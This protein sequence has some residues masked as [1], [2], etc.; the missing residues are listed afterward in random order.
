MG[1]LESLLLQQMSP[2]KSF[3]LLTSL[4]QFSKI[5]KQQAFQTKVMTKQGVYHARKKRHGGRGSLLFATDF[6]TIEL[7]ETSLRLMS[8]IVHSKS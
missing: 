5:V 2:K 6:K 3:L 4:Q 7:N 1:H 8:S